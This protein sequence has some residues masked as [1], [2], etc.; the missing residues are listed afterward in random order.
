MDASLSELLDVFDQ[1]KEV[2]R[3]DR[4][5]AWDAARDVKQ[6]KEAELAHRDRL[7]EQLYHFLRSVG[8]PVNFQKYFYVEERRGLRKKKVGGHKLMDCWQFADKSG[9]PLKGS[10]V[11]GSGQTINYLIYLVIRCSDGFIATATESIYNDNPPHASLASVYMT[12]TLAV[13]YVRRTVDPNV[14]WRPYFRGEN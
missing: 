1:I 10:F 3:D 14:D 5:T 9:K 4:R 2:D 8:A 6:R 13:E 12:I 7:L 11:D